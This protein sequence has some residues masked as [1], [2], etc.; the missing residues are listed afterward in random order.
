MVQYV[1]I[2]LLI[3]LFSFSTEICKGNV[4]YIFLLKSIK[5]WFIHNFL[6]LGND[7]VL[8]KIGN[9][10]IIVLYD[11]YPANYYS[12]I[13]Q[14]S[15]DF[16]IDRNS[17]IDISISVSLKYT[18]SSSY[19]RFLQSENYD[20][21]KNDEN[22]QSSSLVKTIEFHIS[23]EKNQIGYRSAVSQP[24][25]SIKSNLAS[26]R[27]WSEKTRGQWTTRDRERDS[28]ESIKRSVHREGNT[29]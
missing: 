17:P 15:D 25:K 20:T 5:I 23:D 13:V 22:Q 1:Y 14:I 4:K 11:Y 7:Y 24:A 26:V 27:K 3:F 21:T 18:Y 9:L 16:L 8:L 12:T 29:C 28:F 10:Q 19:F 6:R 2:F